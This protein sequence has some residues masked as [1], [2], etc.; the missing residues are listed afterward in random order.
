MRTQLEG[1]IRRHR[2]AAAGAVIL[3]LDQPPELMIVAEVAGSVRRGHDEPVALND[4]WH[5]GSCAKSLTA[6]LYARLVEQGRAAW[7]VPMTDLFEDLAS[8]IHAGW[9]AATIDDLL[10]CR[11]GLPPNPTKHAMKANYTDRRAPIDQRTNLAAETLACPPHRT[12]QFRYS[13]LGYTI[14]GAAIDRITGQPFETALFEELLDPLGV[15]TAGFGPPPRIWGHRSRLEVSGIV[16]GRGTP[17]PPNDI[18]SDNPPLLTPAGRLHLSLAD[19]ARVQRLF[20]DGA[21]LI[22]Q[23]S[24]ERLL[25]LPPDGRGMTMGWA[26]AKPFAG[27]K[28]GMQGS[29]TAW[30]AS[31]LMSDDQQRIVHVIAN[32]GRTRTLTA[33]ARLAAT[34]TP[35]PTEVRR[36]DA[37]TSGISGRSPRPAERLPVQE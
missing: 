16:I 7:S 35:T 23:P 26:E 36:A 21:G 14:A 19:W 29:N 3:D 13:N 15:T 5:I 4:A 8:S 37:P 22:T 17:Q 34:L 18:R 32:D 28:L 1:F 30:S 9:S 31:A 27:L 33:T 10:T 20:L 25:R 11:S 24:L 6:A 12:G 2:V